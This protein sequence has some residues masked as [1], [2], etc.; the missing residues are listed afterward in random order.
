MR[1]GPRCPACGW[2]EDVF[3]VSKAP[4]MWTAGCPMC[5]RY[6]EGRTMDEA[7]RTFVEYCGMSCRAENRRK[8]A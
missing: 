8:K 5:M 6:M 7:H 4:E 1:K 3:M 2:R